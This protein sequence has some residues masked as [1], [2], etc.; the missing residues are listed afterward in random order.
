MGRVSA[1]TPSGFSPRDPVFQK[2][3]PAFQEAWNQLMLT[4]VLFIL[5]VEVFYFPNSDPRKNR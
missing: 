2:N 5:R 4:A 1:D 3:S